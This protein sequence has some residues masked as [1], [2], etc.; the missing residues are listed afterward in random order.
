[1]DP[2]NLHGY[3]TAIVCTNDSTQATIFGQATIDG[4]GSH[5]FRIDVRDLAE[6]GKGSDTYRMRV[7]AYASGDQVL[8]GGNIQ[9]H[10]Q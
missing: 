2:F 7:N 9:I 5:T 10:R 4:S 1:V 6:P 3:V 8:K